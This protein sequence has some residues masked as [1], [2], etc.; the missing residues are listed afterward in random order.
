MGQANKAAWAYT[1]HARLGGEEVTIAKLTRT[2]LGD[3]L[4]LNTPVQP[5]SSSSESD[6]GGEGSGGDD[7]A[8]DD[9]GA[10]GTH[11]VE[12]RHNGE[13]AGTGAGAGAGAGA[14]EQA[15]DADEADDGTAS[16]VAVVRR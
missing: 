8:D 14:V 15:Y 13:G 6:T 7:A 10:N 9:L 4:G 12:V 5:P 11:K 2:K 16:V 1:A 3:V